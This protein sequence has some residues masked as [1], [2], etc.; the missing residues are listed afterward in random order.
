MRKI[1]EFNGYRY[2][3]GPLARRLDKVTGDPK[4]SA[5]WTM[6]LVVASWTALGVMA[7]TVGKLARA[8]LT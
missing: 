8:V 3:M 6:L 5:V 4:V 7:Y 2:E 1:V